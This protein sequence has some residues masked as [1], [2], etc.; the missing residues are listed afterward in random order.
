MQITL[1]RHLPTEWNQKNLLQ[2]RR[3]IC[4]LPPTEELY[5]EINVNLQYLNGLQ[6][7][8][9]VLCS[10][11]RRTFQTAQL[12]GYEAETESLLDELDFGPFEGKRK[13]KLLQEYG[14]KWTKNPRE[15]NFGVKIQ[16][17]EERITVFL[18]KYKNCKNLLVFGHGCWIRG[19]LSFHQFGHIN[20][21][22]Q[23]AFRNNEVITLKLCL[24]GIKRG[25]FFAGN[26]D[27]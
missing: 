16:N 15:L 7:F 11:L 1:I 4:V 26:A 14:E 24:T 20:H 27:L 18:D 8:D 6:P 12:Y 5:K 22:N 2:G 17:L 19:M 21:M 9:L 23:M 10:T 3:D 25:D 13:E